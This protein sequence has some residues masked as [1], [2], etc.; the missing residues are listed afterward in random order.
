MVTPSAASTGDVRPHSRNRVLAAL[1]EAELKMLLPSLA[2]VRL[3][4]HDI[5]ADD[6]ADYRYVYFPHDCLISHVIAMQDGNLI[7]TILLGREGCAGFGMNTRSH[8]RDVVTVEGVAS[9]IELHTLVTAM[10][11]LSGVNR[12]MQA[13][14][15]GLLARVVRTAACGALH[16]L[17]SRAARW[18]LAA[19]DATRQDAFHLTQERFAELLGVR[20]ASV[21]QVSRR[22]QQERAIQYSRGAIRIVSRTGLERLTCECYRVLQSATDNVFATH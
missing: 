14:L 13:Y 15:G 1:P 20:R 18:L 7:E 2:E 5:L 21:N 19:Q 22:F 3:H 6:G 16:S 8:A 12:I 17:E 4:R 10:A 9:R 11:E